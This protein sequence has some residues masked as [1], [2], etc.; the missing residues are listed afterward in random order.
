MNIPSDKDT[1][2]KKPNEAI[3]TTQFGDRGIINGSWPI[4]EST[5][6]FNKAEWPIP[7]F[8]FK[9][10]YPPDKAFIREYGQDETGDLIIIYETLV[11]ASMIV[12]LPVDRSSG[13]GRGRDKAYESFNGI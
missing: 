8:G 11:D 6:P 2:E 12:D 4:I 7:K 1:I 10:P 9:P 3:L 5:R 13:G